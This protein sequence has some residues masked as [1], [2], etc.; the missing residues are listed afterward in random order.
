MNN[1]YIT[2]NRL[3]YPLTILSSPAKSEGFFFYLFMIQVRSMKIERYKYYLSIKSQIIK[4]KRNR[5]KSNWSIY[6]M[7]FLKLKTTFFW[8]SDNKSL[9]FLII[10]LMFG[11]ISLSGS[12]QYID[13][14]VLHL[15]YV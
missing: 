6:Y 13:R 2:K 3:Y 5:W 4:K 7:I 1:V 8:P 11:L 12:I 15:I 10:V 14:H 9:V